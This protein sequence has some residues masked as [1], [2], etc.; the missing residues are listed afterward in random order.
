MSKKLM[1]AL[2]LALGVLAGCSGPAEDSAPEVVSLLSPSGSAPDA[3]TSKA[4]APAAP[5]IRPDTSF[6]EVHRMQQPW[7]RCLKE[8]GVPMET[9]TEGLLEISGEGNSK[10]TNGRLIASRPENEKACGKLRPVFAPE[11]DEEKNP[12]YDDDDD[13]F[14]KCRVEHGEPLVRTN[15]QWRPGPGW[16]DWAPD[17]A[18]Q[19]ACQAQAFDGKKG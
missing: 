16:N 10:E 11:L 17:E 4:A 8:H 12:Y 15:G 5:V 7:M 6:E 1:V 2:T 14:H 18:M 19:L 9:T 3:A 13:N